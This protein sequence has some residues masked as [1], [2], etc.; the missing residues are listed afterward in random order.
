MRFST[1]EVNAGAIHPT[2]SSL[3]EIWFSNLI[4]TPCSKI[5]PMGKYGEEGDLI[6]KNF[7]FGIIHKAE[8]K[9]I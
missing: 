8:M 6:Y 3:Y 9:C 4:E 1:A 2:I 7:E 5:C